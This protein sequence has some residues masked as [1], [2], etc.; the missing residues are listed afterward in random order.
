MIKIATSILSSKNRK[1]C[2]EKLNKTDT[3][4][5]HIDVMDNIFV[6]NYQLPIEEVNELG[7]NSNKPLD[8][9]LMVENPESFI[10]NIAINNIKSITIHLEINKNINNLIEL[11]KKYNYQVG[12]AIKPNTDINKIDKYINLIDKVIIMSVEP[13]FGGQ[14]FIDS[15][16]DRIKSIRS[17]R[18][19]IIIEVDGGINN[20]TIKKI[21][22]DTDIAVVGSYIV[23][24][25]DYQEAINSLKN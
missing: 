4:Y 17:K 6:P 14:T 12:I 21:S 16:V 2:I 25:N 8:V 10:K 1:E 15:S 7:K 23:N 11:I 22:N 24:N 9:H 5:I 3:D 13:G 19:N 18:K 20:E